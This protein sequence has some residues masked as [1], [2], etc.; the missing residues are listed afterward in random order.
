MSRTIIVGDIHGCLS[1]LKRL[2]KQIRYQ[3]EDQLVCVGDLIA[4][5]PDSRGVLALL[6]EVGASCV[7]GNHERRLLAVRQA[8]LNHQS[9]PPLGPA[10][11]Q[12][13]G[14]LSDKD[15]RML[16]AL[17]YYLKLPSHKVV[18]VHAGLEP[19]KRLRFQD[20]WL[21]THM[22]TIDAS[23]NPSAKRGGRLWGETYPGP[24]HVVFGHNAV[25]GLQFHSYA[26]GLDSGCVYGGALSAL[27]LKQGATLPE[28]KK[29]RLVIH[30]V[31]ASRAYYGS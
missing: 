12:L 17:P 10:H 9:G 25:D 20:P 23:G 31:Q 16:E 19:G 28:V 4:R 2:L 30:Q 14:N 1:E 5:G 15:W 13:L 6:R 11:E 8:R 22:R 26:T 7:L 24:S 29:R 3:P 27:V 18:V 21:M